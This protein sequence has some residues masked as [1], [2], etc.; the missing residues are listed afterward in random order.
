MIPT[1]GGSGWATENQRL[2]RD[3]NLSVRRDKP[4]LGTAKDRVPALGVL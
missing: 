4:T 2:S 1:E 3:C